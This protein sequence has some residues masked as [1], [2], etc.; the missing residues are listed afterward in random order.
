MGLRVVHGSLCTHAR[1][2]VC[3]SV[4]VCRTVLLWLCLPLPWGKQEAL[5]GP[6][7]GKDRGR[8]LTPP[9]QDRGWEAM[10]RCVE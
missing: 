5:R 9:G 1:V 10:I 3:M 6:R 8:L 7:E 4:G 2:C